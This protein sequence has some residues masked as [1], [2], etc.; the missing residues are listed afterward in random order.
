MRFPIVT[1]TIGETPC[2]EPFVAAKATKF[3]IN[4]LNTVVRNLAMVVNL[5]YGKNLKLE[6]P[7]TA[8]HIGAH[9]ATINAGSTLHPG[10]GETCCIGAAAGVNE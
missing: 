6:T 2:H 10:Y 4:L 5:S 9:T 7:A 3:A 1:S 8:G